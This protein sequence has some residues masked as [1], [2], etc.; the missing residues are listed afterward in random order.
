MVKIENEHGLI[1][2]SINGEVK[3]VSEPLDRQKIR[4]STAQM[5][6]DAETIQDIKNYLA[7]LHDVNL[8]GGT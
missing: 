4:G 5:L 8:S 6:R 1:K 2:E 7:R 3:T